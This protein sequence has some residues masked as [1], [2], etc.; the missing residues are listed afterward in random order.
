MAAPQHV[1]N[2]IVT[3]LRL[4]SRC[5]WQRGRIRLCPRKADEAAG[6]RLSEGVLNRVRGLELP[7]T[8]RMSS[9]VTTAQQLATF[10]ITQST[11]LLRST[12]N[13]LL[14]LTRT[15]G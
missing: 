10:E 8:V 14:Y 13:S 9:R 11:A 1:H 2:P 4:H 7:C 6:F 5:N 15:D 3:A 12:N